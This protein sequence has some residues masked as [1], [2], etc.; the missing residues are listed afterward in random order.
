MNSSATTSAGMALGN[1]LDANP[2][3]ERKRCG[4]IPH[5]IAQRLGELW[6]IEDA[7]ARGIQEPRHPL[8]I[9]DDRQRAGDHDTVVAGQ[10]P[11]D[12]LVIPLGQRLGHAAPHQMTLSTGKLTTNH[13]YPVVTHS[14]NMWGVA[15]LPSRVLR[16]SVR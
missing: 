10:N 12:P 8:R 9:A 4:P 16:K 13:A 3:L 2:G 1:V 7:N 6:I 14:H 11:R 5:T 15:N